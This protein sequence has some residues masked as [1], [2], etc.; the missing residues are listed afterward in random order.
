MTNHFTIVGAGIA[1]STLAL[2]LL[3]KGHRVTMIAPQHA[4]DGSNSLTS[5]KQP[6]RS[7]LGAHYKDIPTAREM[8]YDSL[9]TLIDLKKLGFPFTLPNGELNYDCFEGFGDRNH[10]SRNTAYIPTKPKH[11]RELHDVCSAIQGKINELWDQFTE[12]EKLFLLTIYPHNEKTKNDQ[13]HPI[14][15]VRPLPDTAFTTGTVDARLQPSSYQSCEMQINGRFLIQWL[16]TEINKHVANS[17]FTYIRG[18]V[19]KILN[20]PNAIPLP[21]DVLKQK[22]IHVRYKTDTHGILELPTNTVVLCAYDK[23]FELHAAYL[24]HLQEQLSR[25]PEHTSA[26]SQERPISPRQKFKVSSRIKII[27]TAEL[28]PEK[29]CSLMKVYSDGSML[30]PWKENEVKYTDQVITNLA[31]QTIHHGTETLSCNEH[32]PIFEPYWSNPIFKYFYEG[33]KYTDPFNIANQGD[34]YSLATRPK[35]QSLIAKDLTSLTEKEKNQAQ[36]ISIT[37]HDIEQLNTGVITHSIENAARILMQNSFTRD[38]RSLSGV[39][40]DVQHGLVITTGSPDLEQ[41][42][43]ATNEQTI[44]QRDQRD[45]LFVQPSDISQIGDQFFGLY[46]RKAMHGNRFIEAAETITLS[47][48]RQ[49]ILKR[50]I[51]QKVQ[52]HREIFYRTVL[53]IDTTTI[54]HYNHSVATHYANVIHKIPNFNNLPLSSLSFEEFNQKKHSILQQFQIALNNIQF[55]VADS[56]PRRN[57]AGS[58]GSNCSDTDGTTTS[59]EESI[60]SIQGNPS[61]PGT[62]SRS[63]KPLQSPE[64]DMVHDALNQSTPEKITLL[65]VD[66]PVYGLANQ[67]HLALDPSRIH[68]ERPLAKQQAAFFG[69]SSVPITGKKHTLARKESPDL[70]SKSRR[71]KSKPAADRLFHQQYHDTHFKK[72]EPP[73]TTG[74]EARKSIIKNTI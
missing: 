69:G 64:T 61:P 39:I 43:R 33:A 13:L 12:E 11:V 68:T 7:T 60:T 4:N 6:G 40:N 24:Q 10:P 9:K 31:S 14:Q 5:N 63:T 41:Q 15:Y 35:K 57:R 66:T 48:E 47:L 72:K 51:D 3:K 46:T 19:S 45:L 29:Q 55:K 74:N 52:E 65:R 42:L 53:S 27:A 21:E 59:C 38:Y 34:F 56:L 26:S 49:N 1:G 25:E 50:M 16:W 36:E 20:K 71:K 44:H 37:D 18:S 54:E 30:T 62:P 22:S 58:F 67:D 23:N 17:Q 28:D 32:Q 73:R 70:E 8:V 2:S